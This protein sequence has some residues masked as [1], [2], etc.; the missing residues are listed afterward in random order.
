MGLAV[1]WFV[2]PGLLATGGLL[3]SR[4]RSW[5]WAAGLAAVGWAGFGL[6]LAAG[7][8]VVVPLV[9]GMYDRSLP[10]TMVHLVGPVSSVVKGVL[11]FGVAGAC[12][13]V[14]WFLAGSSPEALRR[15]VQLTLLMPAGALL[16]AAMTT[17]AD[18]MTQLAAAAL[19]GV[20][21][22]MGLGAG[23]ITTSLRRPR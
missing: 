11:V 12:G 17:P 2:L 15:I 7:V 23:A 22:L 14:A 16:V 3:G 21:W 9:T 4:R 1:A 13:A 8:V 10:G 20:S 6:G 19:I 18:L 5:R